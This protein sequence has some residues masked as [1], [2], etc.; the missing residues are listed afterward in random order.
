[1]ARGM[2]PCALRSRPSFGHLPWSSKNLIIV[3]QMIVCFLFT[4]CCI[5]LVCGGEGSWAKACWIA[6]A[7]LCTLELCQ[8]MHVRRPELAA[9]LTLL[10]W[11]IPR[12]FF[13]VSV[14]CCVTELIAPFYK[15]IYVCCV[16][17]SLPSA[18]LGQHCVA[19]LLQASVMSISAS[20][21]VTI[22]VA[23]ENADASSEQDKFLLLIFL[24]AY[25]PSTEYQRI[26]RRHLQIWT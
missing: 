5:N 8:L 10:G 4:P 9:L 24:Y 17:L 6:L 21:M 12:Q 20:N 2:I 26:K 13:L 11:V 22:W 1:M 3:T 19:A 23:C 7:M 14:V 15:R 18:E 16:T 25:R